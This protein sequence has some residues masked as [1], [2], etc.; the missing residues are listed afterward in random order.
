MRWL[1]RILVLLIVCS[2]ISGAWCFYNA[3]KTAERAEYGLHAADLTFSLI[4]EYVKSHDGELPKSWQDLEALAP[5]SD[6]MYAWPGD[7]AKVREFVTVDFGVTAEQF[8]G[9][10]GTNLGLV[11]PIGSFYPSIYET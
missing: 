9:Q 7:S 11:K 2:V 4:E 6:S 1:P 8:A 5:R 10:S 3:I